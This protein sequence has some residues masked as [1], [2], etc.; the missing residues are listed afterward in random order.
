MDSRQNYQQSEIADVL[1]AGPYEG[2]DCYRLVLSGEHKTKHLRVTPKQAAAIAA[3]LAEPA[4]DTAPWPTKIIDFR[5]SI[6]IDLETWAS[7]YGLTD[8]AEAER[9]VT[10]DFA[11]PEVAEGI[12]HLLRSSWPKLQD[13]DV[14]AKVME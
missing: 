9:D 13:Y 5:L 8:V 2:E 14:T 11:R 7:D 1:A 3:I 12:V 6:I 4:E 10:E